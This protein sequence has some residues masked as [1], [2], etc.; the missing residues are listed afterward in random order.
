MHTK[1]WTP[2]KVQAEEERLAALWEVS[3]ATKNLVNMAEDKGGKD[4]EDDGE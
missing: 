4:D 1:N 2:E 3:E